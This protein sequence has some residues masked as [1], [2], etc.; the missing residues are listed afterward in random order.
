MADALPCAACG[1]SD[2]AVFYNQ[3]NIPMNSMLLLDDARAAREFPRGALELARCATCGFI[4][5]VAYDIGSSEYSQ[6]YEASQAYSPVFNAFADGLAQRW[7]DT[8]NIH[9]KTVLEIGCDKGDFLALMCEKGNNRGIGIDP[10]ADPQRQTG[11]SAH[12]RMTFIADFYSEKYAHLDA[13]V[14]I[15]RHTLEHIASVREFMTTVRAA[16]GDRTDT[17]VLFE[18][19]DVRRVLEDFAFWDLYYEHC[20][21]FTLGSLARLFRATGF[22]VVNLETDFG[23]Q[24]LLVEARPA[25]TTPASGAPL[26]VE[27]DL[28]AMTE[29]VTAFRDGI[30]GRLGGWRS[31]IGDLRAEGRRAVIWGGGSKGVAYLTSLGLQDDIDYAVDINPFK[32]GRFLA[33]C[34]QEVVAP[35]FLREYGPDVVIAMNPIYSEE[36]QTMLD[37]LGVHAELRAV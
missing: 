5:N 1:G 26:A 12:D 11:S 14:V 30:G 15:C 7:V 37:G 20:S 25:S 3:S 33:G 16:L 6:R 28:A 36:I 31:E 10:A 19:P 27:D 17:L 8:H 18:L 24:Y 9:N 34:G 22:E 13:D 23:G 35:E 2:L 4:T 29:I 21:Y 32:Q